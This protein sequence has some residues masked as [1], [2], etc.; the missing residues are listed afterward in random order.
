MIEIEQE[1][2]KK[3]Q[4]VQLEMLVEVDRICKKCTIHYNIIAG[5]LLGAVRHG[6]YIPWDDDADIAMLREEYEKFRRACQTELDKTR[7]YFQDHRNTKGYRWGYGKIR[8][9][10][11]LFL[12]ENQ[13]HMPYEQGIFIDIFPLDGVPDNYYLRSLKNFE[14]FCIRKILWSKVGKIADKNLFMRKWYQIL[15]KIPEEKI[16]HYYH[17]MIRKANVR[18]TQMVRILMFPTPNK[19]Y[20][21]YRKW[22][23]NSGEIVF[24]QIVFQGIADY[25]SYLSFKFGDYMELPPIEQRK[26]HPVSK[27]KV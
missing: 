15:D 3:I 12:R 2:L 24:E 10:D 13:E 17:G 16:F 9:K 7:F 26:I 14:C 19:E 23:E 5:T 25:D 11:T 8:R 27:L 6:G 18:K 20:G 4:A 1:V 21:Y 22:Y